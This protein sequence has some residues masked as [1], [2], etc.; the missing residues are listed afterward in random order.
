M[1][2]LM[3]TNHWPL[4]AGI[5]IGEQKAN[6][7]AGYGHGGPIRRHHRTWPKC[8]VFILFDVVVGVAAMRFFGDVWTPTIERSIYLTGAGSEIAL[9]CEERLDRSD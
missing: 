4:E 7:K 1:G 9:G 3:M 6:V 2:K 5:I 8:L